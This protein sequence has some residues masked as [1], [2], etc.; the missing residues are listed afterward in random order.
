MNEPIESIHIQWGIIMKSIDFKQ[1]LENTEGTIKY[2]QSRETGNIG[3]A[4]VPSYDTRG[5]VCR[6]IQK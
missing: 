6:D 4:T 2:R 1:A 3:M 5:N